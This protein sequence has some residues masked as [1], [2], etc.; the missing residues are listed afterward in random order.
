[1]MKNLPF[2][3]IVEIDE[4]YCYCDGRYFPNGDKFIRIILQKAFGSLTNDKDKPVLTENKINE[5]I[6]GI[7]RS[8]YR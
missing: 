8:T 7:K 1:M 5:I 6:G 2:V 4:I 3:T